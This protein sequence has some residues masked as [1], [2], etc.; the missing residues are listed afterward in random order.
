MSLSGTVKYKK[1]VGTTSTKQFR[2]KGKLSPEDWEECLR[3]LKALLKQYG[4]T[5]TGMR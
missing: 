1:K 5:I 4:V 2:V 3:K